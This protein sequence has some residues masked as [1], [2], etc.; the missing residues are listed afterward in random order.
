MQV[1]GRRLRHAH[2]QQV[3]HLRDRPRVHLLLNRLRIDNPTAGGRDGR[4]PRAFR[5]RP[6]PVRPRGRGLAWNHEQARDRREARRAAGIDNETTTESTTSIPRA[7][8]RAETVTSLE[9]CAALRY[10]ATLAVSDRV[11]APRRRLVQ[12]TTNR[13]LPTRGVRVSVPRLTRVL[14]AVPRS[15]ACATMRT[16]FAEI[17]RFAPVDVPVL[18][19]GESGTGKG[20]GA[21]GEGNPAPERAP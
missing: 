9:K 18:I 21:R 14:A 10:S 2:G 20:Q 12:S 4:A 19:R 1:S 16:L 17:E 5:T 3:A 13:Q 8:A 6:A 15:C 7:T 11:H